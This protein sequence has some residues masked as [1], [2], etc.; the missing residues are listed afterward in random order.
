MGQER[1]ELD[2]LRDLADLM[3]LDR[4]KRPV[5]RVDDVEFDEGN[6]PAIVAILVG[7]PA[8]AG[9]FSSR[10]NGWMRGAYRRLDAQGRAKPVRIGIEHVQTIDSRVDVDVAREDLGIG[11]LDRWIIGTTIGKIPGADHAPE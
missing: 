8:L 10:L 11:E 9:R 7:T 6:P 2:V 5:G 4:D 3:I 1:R